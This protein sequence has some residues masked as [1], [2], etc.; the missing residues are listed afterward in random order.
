LTLLQKK[1]F[2]EQVPKI[3]FALPQQW[4]HNSLDIKFLEHSTL[5]PIMD[6]TWT[7]KRKLMIHLMWADLLKDA[8]WLSKTWKTE[9]KMLKT[10]FI[11]TTLWRWE[12]DNVILNIKLKPK[13]FVKFLTEVTHALISMKYLLMRTNN[14]RSSRMN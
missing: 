8:L 7:L 1:G 11:G 3:K 5:S 6:L 14:S 12:I 2:R 4:V 10:R 13:S 9:Q